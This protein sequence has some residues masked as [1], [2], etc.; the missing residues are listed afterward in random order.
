MSPFVG[1]TMWHIRYTN[2][3]VGAMCNYH[4][5]RYPLK[6][7]HEIKTI[8]ISKN[9]ILGDACAEIC[10]RTSPKWTSERINS[11]TCIYP[12]GPRML[13]RHKWRFSSCDSGAKKRCNNPGGDE[14]IPGV[15]GGISKVSLI[16]AIFCPLQ[17]HLLRMA[18]KTS[19]KKTKTLVA[20]IHT[21]ATFIMKEIAEV[22]H[23]EKEKNKLFHRWKWT[24]RNESWRFGSWWFSSCRWVIFRFHVN[25]TGLICF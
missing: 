14:C 25:F 1:S 24:A 11:I 3:L 17:V 19:G 6:S 10:V 12:P 13:A 7:G 22:H 15:Q 9:G 5:Q 20:A 21:P 8:W 2:C 18:T 16:E 4:D 23:L